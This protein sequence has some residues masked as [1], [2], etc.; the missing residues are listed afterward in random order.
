M[1]FNPT[2]FEAIQTQNK[3]KSKALLNVVFSPLIAGTYGFAMF[4]TVLLLLK[5]ISSFASQ[6]PLSVEI[7]DLKIPLIGFIS[8][9]V[10]SFFLK[11]D[12]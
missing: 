9:F 1:R 10:L 3:N 7:Y 4:F 12:K 2:L 11:R 8:M 5:I 6:Q